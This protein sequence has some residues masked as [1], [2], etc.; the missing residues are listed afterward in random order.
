MTPLCGY[1]QVAPTV[2]QTG[3]TYG[4]TN[5]SHLWCYTQVAP[6]ALHTGRTY[7]AND[8]SGGIPRIYKQDAATRLGLPD[9]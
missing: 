8:E 9:Q 1:T 4:A 3:R 5:R 2:L 6:M 7:G